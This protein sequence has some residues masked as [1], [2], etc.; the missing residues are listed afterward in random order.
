MIARVLQNKDVKVFFTYKNERINARSIM[1]IL[2]LLAKKNSTVFIY[3]EGK[4]AK[5]TAKELEKLFDGGFGD[6]D[7]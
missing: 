2:S 3:V 1:G 7:E 6:L 5:I 4:D